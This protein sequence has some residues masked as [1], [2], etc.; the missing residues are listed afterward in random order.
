MVVVSDIM[1]PVERVDKDTPLAEA[2]RRMSNRTGMLVVTSEDFGGRVVGVLTRTDIVRA[3]AR[4]ECDV[5][6]QEAMTAEII[7][8]SPD[9]PVAEAVLL[10]RRHALSRLPVMAEGQAVG[11]VTSND[12]VTMDVRAGAMMEG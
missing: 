12:M 6:V 7:S 1:G 4:N 3:V 8:V 2:A 10:L 5:K 11:I 9:A